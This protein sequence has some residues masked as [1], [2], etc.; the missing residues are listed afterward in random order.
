MVQNVLKG[1]PMKLFGKNKWT[2]KKKNYITCTKEFF[3]VIKNSKPYM[4]FFFN[5]SIDCKTKELHK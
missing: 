1:D 3:K 5:K 4:H 2:P